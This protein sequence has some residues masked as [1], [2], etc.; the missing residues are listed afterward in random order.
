MAA[1]STIQ[2][3]RRYLVHMVIGIIAAL[4]LLIIGINNLLAPVTLDNTGAPVRVVIPR[5]AT[6]ENIARILAEEGLIKNE[7]LFRLLV[8][9]NG[10]EAKL[11][12]G[13][14]ELSPAMAPGEIIDR[15]V[16]G[17]TVD[18]YVRVTIPEGYTVLQVADLLAE[19]GLVDR[20]RFLNLVQEGAFAFDF[21]A[22]IPDTVQYRL[23]GYLF[24]D[25]YYFAPEAGE[26]TVINRMLQRFAEVVTPEFRERARELGMSLHELITLASIVEREARLP[27]ERPIIAGVFHNRLQLGRK[28]ESCATIQYILGEPKE[29]LL[30]EDTRIPSPYNTY[31]HAGLPPGPIA[32]PGEASIRAAAYP[33]ET[34]YLYFLADNDGS[35]IF[36]RTLEEHNQAKKRVQR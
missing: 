18:E 4:L 36:S 12:A 17:D 20:E 1:S 27:E 7:L 14:Y 16:Q 30:T 25:T 23:E 24:P 6:G 8:R 26:E 31:L 10:A 15:L 33:E 29:R 19:K 22:E 11:Q 35:H 3:A 32:A 5:G 21:L 28:L 9:W 13:E 34:E 2:Q